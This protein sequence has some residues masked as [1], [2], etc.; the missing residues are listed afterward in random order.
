MNEVTATDELPAAKQIAEIADGIVMV[1]A[2][3]TVA[4]GAAVASDASGNITISS[5]NTWRPVYAWKLSELAGDNDTIDEVLANTTGT[6]PLR[7]GSS[8]AYDS[9]TNNELE[10]VWLEIDSSG[11]KTYAI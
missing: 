11:N 5:T 6:N 7:F 4:A 10:L 8:F 1:E 2:G 3:G 9:T